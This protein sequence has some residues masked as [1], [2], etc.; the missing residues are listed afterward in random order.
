MGIVHH[1]SYLAY[2]EDGRVEYLRRRG[3]VYSSWSGK[4]VHLP[5]VEAQLRYRRPAHFD[6]L[7]Q[8]ETRLG[9]LRGAS[10]RF[11]YRILRP[12][13]AGEPEVLCEG[14]TVLA[15]VDD[16]RRARRLPPEV[17]RVFP[18]PETHPAQPGPERA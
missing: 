6:D 9:E 16:A 4:G 14:H 13:E 2:F 15:C 8:V 3:V 17:L 18:G 5:V 11:D 1:A 7:L 12:R 10:L